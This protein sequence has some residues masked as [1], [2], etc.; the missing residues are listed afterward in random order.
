MAASTAAVKR[1]QQA[2][3]SAYNAVMEVLEDEEFMAETFESMRQ[4]QSGERGKTLLEI[5]EE[6]GITR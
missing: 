2:A 3:R 1:S 6:H 4:F 5:Q